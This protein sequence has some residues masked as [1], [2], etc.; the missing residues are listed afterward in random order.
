MNHSVF[1]SPLSIV[2]NFPLVS[3]LSHHQDLFF[4]MCDVIMLHY[5]RIYLLSYFVLLLYY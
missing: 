4:L 2:S 1:Q 5:I 3:K